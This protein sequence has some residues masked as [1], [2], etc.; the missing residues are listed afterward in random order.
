MSTLWFYLLCEFLLL[1]AA[2][3]FYRLRQRRTARRLQAAMNARHDEKA[4]I[5]RELHDKLLQSAQGM[6]L[7]F[8]SIAGRL[9]KSDPTRVEMERALVYADGLL[10]EA[11]DSVRALRADERDNN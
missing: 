2:F 4:R 8:Q 7:L 3:Q 10:N 6:M 5:A 1:A 11:R 9:H